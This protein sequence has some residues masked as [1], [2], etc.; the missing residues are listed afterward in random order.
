MEKCIFHSVKTMEKCYLIE[1]ND[2][3]SI[4]P[5]EIKSGKDYTNYRTLP[6]IISNQNYPIQRG[7]N[8]RTSNRFTH[9]KK[10]WNHTYVRDEIL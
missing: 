9:H 5:I 7:R 6:K 2:N 8:Q 4:L 1:G 10:R 3:L